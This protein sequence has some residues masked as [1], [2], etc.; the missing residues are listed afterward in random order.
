MKTISISEILQQS[1]SNQLIL[2]MPCDPRTLISRADVDANLVE[3]TCCR[4]C[5]K[6]Y[7]DSRKAPMFCTHQSFKL[8]PAC[9]EALFIQKT[10]HTGI[11]DFGL[12]P[13]EKN[14]NIMPINYHVP[15]F[16]L[17][18]QPISTWL[19]WLLSKPDT[20]AAIETW[21]REIKSSGDI[22]VDFQQPRKLLVLPWQQQLSSAQCVTPKTTNLKNSR[23][24]PFEKNTRHWQQQKSQR[25]LNLQMHK[26][27]S[28]KRQVYAGLS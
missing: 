20:E 18:S 24:D 14:S 12:F 10:T 2:K 19:T 15:R 17:V 4:M 8:T 13:P 28:S 21:E 7:P 16:L 26:M 23:S 5:F 3:T 9:K 25:R 1:S 6:L 27:Q 22:L 11:K